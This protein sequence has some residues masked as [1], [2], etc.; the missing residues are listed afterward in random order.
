L[1]KDH[2]KP[3]HLPPD[4]GH[5]V[6][7]ANARWLADMV[8]EITDIRGVVNNVVDG[9]YTA[10]AVQKT[11][12]IFAKFFAFSPCVAA[13]TDFTTGKMIEVNESFTRTTG[14]SRQELIDKTTR[15]LHFFVDY[16]ERERMLNAIRETGSVRNCEIQIRTKSG[17]IILLDFFGQSISP[18]GQGLLFTQA[19]DITARKKAEDALRESQNQ[20]E[21]RVQERSA[22]LRALV[23]ELTLTE[24]RERQRI[25]EVLH[26][27]L[28][29]LLVGARLH[30]ATIEHSGHRA[31]AHTVAE[32]DSLLSQAIECSQSLTCELCPRV[33]QED[34][35]VPALNWLVQWMR[36]KYGLAV[37]LEIEAGFDTAS[38]DLNILLFQ[39][40]RELLFNIVKHAGIKDA[41][42]RVSQHDGHLEVAVSDCGAGFDPQRLAMG[43]H[44]CG[45][46]GLFSIRERLACLGGRM[47][48]I[49][50]PQ[51]GSCIT[52]RLPCDE[53]WTGVTA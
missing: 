41:Q 4:T 14:Y 44:S 27:H 37:T 51:Q 36:D 33:L 1:K 35:F 40:V 12:Q 31:T 8:A 45:G 25:A 23:S 39:A 52:L 5:S 11:E 16:A 34:G 13:I 24:H 30:L 21:L 10:D 9:K 19:I 28:Q 29:Q 47:E 6:H 2:N 49:S 22:Q 38:G 43:N 32:V 18:D 17:E 7:T 3:K 42:I 48:I 20:L 15:E 26:N 53:T 50:Q 46:F